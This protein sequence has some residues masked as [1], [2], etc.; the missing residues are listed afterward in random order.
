MHPPPSRPALPRITAHWREQFHA[1]MPYRVREVLLVSSAYDAFLL[2]EDGPLTHRL[3]ATFAE[4]ELSWAPR[5]THAS[6]AE[7]ALSLL[8]RRPFQLVLVASSLV[9]TDVAELGRQIRALH[10]NVPVV[11]LVFDE[12]QLRGPGSVKD[13]QFDQTFL[14]SGDAGIL[15]AVVKL[16]EDSLNLEHDVE[17]AD[18]H[19]VLVVEDSV[20]TYSS[21]LT[22]LYPELLRQ[23]RSL[24]AE[25]V[26]EFHR[27]LRIHA[28]PKIVLARNFEDATYMAS[29]W[30]SNLMGVISDV[31][32]PRDGRQDEEAGFQLLEILRHRDDPPPVLLQSSDASLAARAGALDVVFADKNSP[33]A[34]Q[35]VRGFLQEHLGFGDFTFRLADSTPVARSRSVLEMAEALEHVPLESILHHARRHDFSRWLKARSMFQIARYT[36]HITIE[37]FQSP[38]RVRT[39]L[40]DLLREASDHDQA[41]VV[42]DLAAGTRS[43]SNR[44][45]R[46]GSGSIGG[47]A[48]SIGFVSALLVQEDLLHRF[49]ELEIRIPKTVAISVAEY[50]RFVQR[51][52]VKALERLDDPDVRRE[53]MKAQLSD[54]LLA[55]LSEA[56]SAVRGPLAVRSSSLREDA[57]FQAFAGVYATY[58]LPNNHPDP[59]VRFMELRRAI[60][61]VYASMFSRD[62][63]NYSAIHPHVAEDE[64]MAVVVQ[65]VVGQR[66]EDRFYPHISGVAQSYNYYPIGAQR[67]DEGLAV[68][69][70]G[71]GQM[72]VGGRGGLR[73]SPAHP[74]VLPQFTRPSQVLKNTQRQFYALDMSSPLI[75]FAADPSGLLRLYELD[76][77]ERDGTL[78]L[79]GSVYSA[80]D[81]AIR[82]NLS[83]P[84][85]RIV[86]FANVLR[87]NAIP[88]AEAIQELLSALGRAMSSEVEIEFA[89]DMG[90]WGRTAPRGRPVRKPRLYVLQARPM[91]GHEDEP[92]EVNFSAHSPEETLIRTEQSLGNGHITDVCDL[93]YVRRSNLS[94]NE[95][96]A[97]AR[98]IAEVDRSLG[99][100]GRRYVLMGP[101][102]WGSSDPHLGIPVEWL[103]ISHARVIIETPLRGE[104]LESS[105]GT[106]FFHNL[107]TARAGYVTASPQANGYIDQGWLDAQPCLRETEYVRHV[108]LESP[109]RIFLDG[110]HGRALVLKPG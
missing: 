9:G 92:T 27:L 30:S 55:E 39:Y 1:L 78:A 48:R 49:P 71:L 94:S 103:H 105:Q 79:A 51:V 99:A 102:R 87:W 45:L 41:G 84:G 63:R 18:V 74:K 26:N 77:A 11:L 109:L 40:Q 73:F 4:L 76:V 107:T 81:D 72:V 69:A 90:D 47:K 34:M 36:R 91:A 16:I 19:L 62:A 66:H 106:H 13:T 53:V 28:R 7:A 2:E 24:I 96:R 88:L 5:I 70:L 29:R 75:D 97:L 83:L 17:T 3:F 21:F 89:V 86:T 59:D 110:R 32:F 10:P 68:I 43:P 37:D 56:Y 104:L 46:I 23:S 54:S 101:G 108:Q 64:K 58:M 65:Q 20:R 60:K 98:E 80:D 25:G 95:T 33:D 57:R 50:D 67:A 22:L 52:D 14:W 61:A 6:T 38:E 44:F 85:P 100:Q 93:V 8:N 42:T 15:I 35:V 12:G 82:E 31:S